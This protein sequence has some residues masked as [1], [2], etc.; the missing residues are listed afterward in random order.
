MIFFKSEPLV[1][2]YSV[3]NVA[4]WL[5]SNTLPSLSEIL[6]GF[7]FEQKGMSIIFVLRFFLGHFG[8]QLAF[9]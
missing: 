7:D 1:V 9:P 3:M 6:F 2:K 4:V 5:L 8:N